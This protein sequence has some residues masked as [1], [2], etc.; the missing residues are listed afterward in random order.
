MPNYRLKFLRKPSFVEA[1]SYLFLSFS[2]QNHS[3]FRSRRQLPSRQIKSFEKKCEKE[4]ILI[5]ME[6]LVSNNNFVEATSS[7]SVVSTASTLGLFLWDLLARA[8]GKDNPRPK[9]VQDRPLPWE[10]P[11]FRLPVNDVPTT[12]SRR[13]SRSKSGYD[14]KNKTIP[15]KLVEDSMPRIHDQLPDPELWSQIDE[16]LK[17][18][19]N[20][21]FTSV[22]KKLK[23]LRT[24]GR[25][26]LKTV[27]AVVEIQK[28]TEL[29]KETKTNELTDNFRQLGSHSK[30]QKRSL[31]GHPQLEGVLRRRQLYCRT[32]YHIQIQS[33]GRVTGTD[34]DHDLHGEFV[35][36]VLFW[37]NM[38]MTLK[39]DMKRET[40]SSKCLR[41]DNA[42]DNGF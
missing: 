19:E 42:I 39:K 10:G 27:P 18:Q 40:L 4:N 3:P 1:S 14:A 31:T 35:L 30:R 28:E 23:F 17:K 13:K 41:E 16:K 38:S 21:N 32:G 15:Q 29:S 8:R 37:S 11:R 12:Y 2:A 24:R 6:M 9:A 20:E 7:N 33:N 22:N 5:I 26:T 36:H 25:R 34:K